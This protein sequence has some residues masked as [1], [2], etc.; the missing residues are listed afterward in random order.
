MGTLT[1]RSLGQRASCPLHWDNGRLARCAGRERCVGWLV[2]CMIATSCLSLSADVRSLRPL[3]PSQFRPKTRPIR[4]KPIMRR[5]RGECVALT[6]ETRQLLSDPNGLQRKLKM[7]AQAFSEQMQS[8]DESLG[9]KSPERFINESG[10]DRVRAQNL[11]SE[12][13]QMAKLQLI[14]ALE[15]VHGA[16]RAQE[17]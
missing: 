12:Q 16:M 13:L 7:N 9:K 14:Q 6:P 11:T 10:I 2:A 3:P 8:V 17:R 4:Q 1:D 5:G 15:M